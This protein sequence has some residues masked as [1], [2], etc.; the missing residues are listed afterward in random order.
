MFLMLYIHTLYVV[1]QN[2]PRASAQRGRL[3]ELLHVVFI[4]HEIAGAAPGATT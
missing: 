3:V 4:V 1:L 2:E